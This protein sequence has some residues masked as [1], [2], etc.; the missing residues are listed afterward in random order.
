MRRV[1]PAFVAL[2]FVF[3]L[4]AG[5]GKIESSLA[6]PGAASPPSA[7]SDR[8]VQGGVGSEIDSRSV[9][10]LPP[11]ADFEARPLSGPRP[12]SVSFLNTSKDS[13]YFLWDFGDGRSSKE[14]HP[15]HIY[16]QIGTYTVRLT[17]FNGDR[18][19]AKT[20][21]SYIRVTTLPP[22]ADFAA[23]PLAGTPPLMVTFRNLSRNATSYSWKFGDGG[24]SIEKSPVHRYT[25]VGAFTVQLTAGN[26]DGID[27]KIQKRCIVVKPIIPLAAFEAIPPKGTVPLAV[28]FKN[29]SKNA[30]TYHW[31]FGDGGFSTDETPIHEYTRV[32]VF[33]VTLTVAN[34]YLKDTM[35]IARGV[36]VKAPVPEADFD[37]QP[38]KG[39]APLSVSFTNVSRNATQF[40]WD[41]GDGTSSME[42]SPV[43]DYTTVGSYS[44]TLT[45]GNDY[46]KDS[47]TRADYIV[48]K[49]VIPEA[50]FKAEPRRGTVPLEVSFKNMSKNA[51]SFL[52][53]FGDGGSTSVDR[54]P[55]H[56]YTGVGSYSV[57]LTARYGD[58][59]DVKKIANYIVVNPVPPVADFAAAPRQGTEPLTVRFTNKSAN[60]E[61]YLWDFGDGKTSRDE[62]PLHAYAKYGAYTVTLTASK[63]KLKDI[64]KVENC[65][66]VDPAAPVAGFTADPR[67]GPIPLRVKFK[68]TSTSARS[69]RWDFGDGHTSTRESPTHEYTEVG[70]YTVRL[71]VQN[72][73]RK[74]T[75]VEPGYITAQPI[76]PHAD[77][78]GSPREGRRPLT[79]NFINTSSRASSYLWDFGDGGS[80][81]E[82]NPAHEY[83]RAGKY[84]VTL[85]A[86]NG[87]TTHKKVATDYIVVRE[88]A[89]PK[90]DFRGA[91]LQGVR[92]LTVRFINSSSNA[93]SYLWDFGDGGSSQELNPA[94]EYTV[95]GKFT[96]TLVAQK[97]DVTDLMEK[98][99]YVSISDPTPPKSAFSATPLSGA[100]PLLVSF[101]N[102][103]TGAST[104]EWDFGDGETSTQKNPTHLYDA[105]G[106]YT[107]SLTAISGSVKD[108]LTK[109]SYIV[110]TEIPP[111]AV[112][113]ASPTEGV[114]PL[115]VRFFNWSSHATSFLW[116][117]GDGM[118]SEEEEPVHEYTKAGKY[119]VRLTARNGNLENNQT[120]ADC[121]TVYDPPVTKAAFTFTP[122]KGPKPLTVVF[123]NKSTH[124]YWYE[125]SFGDGTTSVEKNPTHLYQEAGVYSVSLTASYGDIKDSLTQPNCITVTELQPKASFTAAPLKGH[126]PLKVSFLNT[127]SNANS[128]LWDFGD[129]TRSQEENPV[130]EYT[131]A[132]KYTVTLTASSGD[133]A[134]TVTRKSLIVVLDIVPPQAGFEAA[135]LNGPKPLRVNFSNTSSHAKSYLW[136]FGDA[137]SSQEENP[138][139]EY[140]QAGKYTVSLMAGNGSLTDTITRKDL[141]TVIEK[142][143]PKAGFAAAPVSGPRP[144]T[145]HFTNTSTGATS[146]IWDFGDGGSSTA[147]S[148]SHE[149]TKVGGF[150]VKLMASNGEITDTMTR[151]D[152]VTVTNPVMTRADFECAPRSGLMPLTVSC[153]NFSTGATDFLWSFG[154]GGSSQIPNPAHDYTKYGNFTVSLTARNGEVADTMVKEKYITVAKPRVETEPNDDCTGADKLISEVPIT[155]Q[156]GSSSDSDCYYF[157]TSQADS[158]PIMF[159]YKDY[160]GVDGQ[161]DACY[162]YYVTAYDADKGTTLLNLPIFITPEEEAIFSIGAEGPGT[163][164]INVARP[165]KTDPQDCTTHLNDPYTL[166][167][168]FTEPE[169]E[170]SV[171]VN[172]IT[173]PRSVKAGSSV[174][175]VGTIE[176]RMESDVDQCVVK[177]VLARGMKVDSKMDHLLG[178]YPAGWLQAGASVRKR[179]LARVP[180][181]LDVGDYYVGALVECAETGAGAE[182]VLHFMK[183]ARQ[184]KVEGRR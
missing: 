158:I 108:S 85:I 168:T 90:A 123:T 169:K 46:S 3:L 167:A 181:D 113:F 137:K 107:V 97:G 128:Y 17:A 98:I 182:A 74:S 109:V 19:D 146:F 68:S 176:N 99:G 7:P 121:I 83:T 180:A 40:H 50:G 134:D 9:I 94:H 60:A 141:I 154:D 71:T 164:Y 49:P 125:W 177:M 12:L 140:S 172:S 100:T 148:P 13:S 138:V 129:A 155:G 51:S 86:S 36:V 16:R 93:E 95:A 117:F 4:M 112:F 45:A 11:D 124:A 88:T 33:K 184:I 179:F 162:R 10:F 61:Q 157:I 104:Y 77:F 135:P 174:E 73:E 122:K 5:S 47:K 139:H 92:P 34:D 55:V 29:S 91:P 15:V 70:S 52:W 28:L 153:I 26:Q 114:W 119:T 65:I 120:Q 102:E 118:R 175:I 63:G 76:P 79:V 145:V 69:F 53:D 32:G 178:T 35:T 64:Q 171:A 82:E 110:V 150:T 80:G 22:V 133:L 126:R 131:E 165:P 67:L 31:D 2:L 115:E 21:K 6:Q 87:E 42:A 89:R 163:Y 183:S 116:D 106:N 54:E 132:G 156:L 142:V 81:K 111:K 58:L 136:D 23:T 43:H 66:T 1:K 62:S 166:I 160:G 20:R 105:P 37:C 84:T 18:S 101:T 44:V 149:Y 170:A 27:T 30:T 96:V 48:V 143:A 127:S 8:G 24:L 144:L 151:A 72:G 25:E 39:V 130:H 147:E 56:E 78:L 57:T 152:Y 161:D 59:K 38:R 41:F 14:V 103:S 173:A 75:S 159:R